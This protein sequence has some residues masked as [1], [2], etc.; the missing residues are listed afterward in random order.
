MGYR[1][2]GVSS[3]I[4]SENCIQIDLNSSLIFHPVFSPKTHSLLTIESVE[5]QKTM[6]KISHSGIIACSTTKLTINKLLS[7]IDLAKEGYDTILAFRNISWCG[8]QGVERI[9]PC[10][11]SIFSGNLAKKDNETKQS[12]YDLF[13]IEGFHPVSEIYNLFV[14]FFFQRKMFTKFLI[15]LI[16]W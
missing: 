12:K 13:N 6:R 8:I 11:N 14:I 9:A 16:Y 4:T 10:F 7:N 15:F 5:R 1:L 2:H 3:E